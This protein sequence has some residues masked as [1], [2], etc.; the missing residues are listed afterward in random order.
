VILWDSP[1]FDSISAGV[2]QRGLLELLGRADAYVVVL[3]KEK[4]ADLSVWTM[5]R[6]RSI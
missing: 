3:S 6:L 5:L 2:Y 1:D 4:Y